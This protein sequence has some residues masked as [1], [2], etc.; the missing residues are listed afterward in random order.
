MLCQKEL[1]LR[2]TETLLQCLDESLENAPLAS[3]EYFNLLSS[4]LT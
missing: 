3:E 1:R 2:I 4:L